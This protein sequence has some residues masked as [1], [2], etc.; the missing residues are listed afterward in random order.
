MQKGRGCVANSLYKGIDITE[1]KSSG[2]YPELFIDLQIQLIS[3]WDG[4]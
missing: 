3:A 2:D 4:A 1:I